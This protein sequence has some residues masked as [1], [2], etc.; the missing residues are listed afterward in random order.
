MTTPRVTVAMLIYRSP[1]WL[2]FALEQLALARN[3]VEYEVLVIG[4][5]AS[6]RVQDWVQKYGQLVHENQPR[7]GDSHLIS[8]LC[9]YPIRDY[10]IEF[11]YIEHRNP[12]PY[13]YYMGRIYRAWNRA[14]EESRTD[15][16]ALVNSDMSFADHWLDELLAMRD[17]FPC[18]PTSLLIESGRVP[19]GLP[20]QVRDFGR[21]W[22][23]FDR[24][25]F[26]ARAEQI[27]DG[28]GRRMAG[29][30]FMPVLFKRSEF[31]AAG[32]YPIQVRDHVLASD[33]DLFQRFENEMKRPHV[34]AVRSVVYHVQRG[35]MEDDVV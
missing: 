2:R 23:T 35:E 26:L 28:T 27:R 34:T 7:G 5:D 12:D 11:R 10:G 22:S 1:E 13:A 19:S 17:E 32:G 16:V 14:V 25:A 20:D 6:S 33:A 15:Y 8:A 4:N 31:L 30:L 9:E 18:L 24:A 3:D 21:H 29:G